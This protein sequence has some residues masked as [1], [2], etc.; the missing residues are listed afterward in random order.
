MSSSIGFEKRMISSR[1]AELATYSLGRGSPVLFLHGGPGD[2]HHYMRRMAEPLI[3]SHRCIFFDQRGTGASKVNVRE[4]NSF[5]VSDMVLDLEAIQDAYEAKGA[6]LVGHSWGAMYGLLA[7]MKS[8]ERYSRAALLNMGPVTDE[9]GELYS[10]KFFRSMT[11]TD[12]SQWDHLRSERNEA[13]DRGH[14]ERVNELDRD[15]MKLRVKL[16]I[17]DSRL[18]ESYLKDYFLDPPPDREVNSWV[19]TS[20]QKEFE[21]AKVERATTPIWLLAGGFDATPLEQFQK[22]VTTLK[23]AQ[24]NVMDACGH[25]PW[26]EKP[27][28]FYTMLK[29]FLAG[30]VPVA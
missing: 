25:V 5:S 6:A 12:R 19:W 17:F 14:V 2:T 28:E 4:P 8:P 20:F 23:F 7:C 26:F 30:E 1:G 29:R 11:E 10:Q 13:R 9:F 3:D 21:F 15:L 24:F 22:L 27:N 18:H 16:W